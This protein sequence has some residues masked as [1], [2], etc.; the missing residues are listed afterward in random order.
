MSDLLEASDRRGVLRNLATF[1]GLLSLGLGLRSVNPGA[2]P[3]ASPGKTTG[4]KTSGD[5]S[6]SGDTWRVRGDLSNM[7]SSDG[8]SPSIEPPLHSVKRRERET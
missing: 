2:S 3:K 5:G 7:R 1:W 6:G 8:T 4:R